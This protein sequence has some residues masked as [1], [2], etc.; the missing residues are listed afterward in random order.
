VERPRGNTPGGS[1]DLARLEAARARRPGRHPLARAQLALSRAT[2]L[3]YER[4]ITDELA[5]IVSTK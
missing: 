5:G 2:A 3:H 1:I 4:V